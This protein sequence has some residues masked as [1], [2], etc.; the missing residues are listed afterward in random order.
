[1]RRSFCSNSQISM[2]DFCDARPAVR[3][4][5]PYLQQLLVC[6]AA[7]E[8]SA[9]PHRC[10]ARFSFE[11]YAAWPATLHNRDH[12]AQIAHRTSVALRDP[13][14]AWAASN[15]RTGSWTLMPSCSTLQPR[16]CTGHPPVDPNQQHSRSAGAV[17]AP[18]LVRIPPR[19]V[20]AAG[21]EGWQLTF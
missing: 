3:C 7:P 19:R 2:R 4:G 13:L 11:L 20:R 5:A 15:K 10:M 8:P 16:T 6:S 1:M 9:H 21:Q 17:R 12:P 18:Q 14:W